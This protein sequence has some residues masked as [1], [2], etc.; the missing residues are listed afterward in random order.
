MP[1]LSPEIPGHFSKERMHLVNLLQRARQPVLREGGLGRILLIH[2]SAQETGERRGLSSSEGTEVAEQRGYVQMWFYYV[3]QAGGGHVPTL[4]SSC[5][6]GFSGFWQ[7]LQT[8]LRTEVCPRVSNMMLS[9]GCPP[10]SWDA[11][12]CLYTKCPPLP[13][14]DNQSCIHQQNPP[15]A[16]SSNYLS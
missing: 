7:H 5:I 13:A 3:I 1:I 15:V 14:I 6:F 9:L 8:A 11:V 16:F 12:R 10:S 2:C 4:T